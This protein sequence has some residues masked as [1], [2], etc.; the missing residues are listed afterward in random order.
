[1]LPQSSTQYMPVSIGMPKVAGP[2]STFQGPAVALVMN[3]LESIQKHAETENRFIYFQVVPTELPPAPAEATV[4]NP[5]PY[6]E[7]EY[8]G[9]KVVFEY[10]APKGILGAMFSTLMSAASSSNIS[11]SSADKSEPPPPLVPTVVHSSVTSVP[12]PI[13]Y[14]NTAGVQPAA[15]PLP[16]PVP[17]PVSSSSSASH[18]TGGAVDS[19]AQRLADE[20]YA[21]Q[22]QQQFNEA[23]RQAAAAA[24]K[25]QHQQS[26]RP[27]APQQQQQQQQY[28]PQQ[29]PYTSASSMGYVYNSATNTVSAPTAPHSA[30]PP[31]AAPQVYHQQPPQYA[32]YPPQQQHVP[33]PQ[34]QQQYAPP[35]QQQQYYAAP[36]PPTTGGPV[37]Y[38][39]VNYPQL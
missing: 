23:D 5:T 36:N 25:P 31:P 21:R 22:L 28:Q 38:N 17:A 12:P 32:G 4:M 9:E 2:Y 20:E 8:V 18:S 3:R 14:Q 16:A 34:Y 10:V 30:P 27:P 11:S 15:A 29:A 39:G 26:V 37:P 19:Y 1:M 24:P 7:P 35:G 13:I 6:A 33:P